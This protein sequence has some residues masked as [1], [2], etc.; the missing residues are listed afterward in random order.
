[1]LLS[2]NIICELPRVFLRIVSFTHFATSI[3]IYGCLFVQQKHVALKDMVLYSY[4]WLQQRIWNASRSEQ[5]V[6][7]NDEAWDDVVNGTE[8]TI[9]FSV[10]NAVLFP[11]EVEK[12]MWPEDYSLS[13]HA[14]LTVVFSPLRMP[15]SRLTSWQSLV[16]TGAEHG[17]K[18][19]SDYENDRPVGIFDR[20]NWKRCDEDV[21]QTRKLNRWSLKSYTCRWILLKLEVH[22]SDIQKLFHEGN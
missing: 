4:Y 7:V 17:N 22:C 10:K 5:G 16:T 20:S 12:G 13:D 14:R 1:M 2:F 21:L 6:E 11:T 18:I 9:G 8:Q 3:K 15:C 19:T